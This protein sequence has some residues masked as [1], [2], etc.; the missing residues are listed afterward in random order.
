MERTSSYRE[1]QREKAFKLLETLFRDTGN[2]LFKQTHYPF[3]LQNNL[4]NLWSGIRYDAINYFKENKIPW[5]ENENESPTG[6]L[7]S[8]QLA[9]V[10]HLYYLRQRKELATVILHSVDN[11]I[12]EAVAIDSK[13][14]SGFVDFEVIGKEN[15]LH[16]RSHTRGALSTSIDAVMVGK[17][18]GGKNI[19][20]LIEWKWTE[21]YDNSSHH[22]DAHDTI[23]L[24]LLKETDCPIKTNI[25]KTENF[26]ELYIEPFFQLMRQTLLGWKMSEAK[27]YNCDEYIHL[28]IIPNNNK[29]LRDPEY[30]PGK[31]LLKAWHGLLKE[32][33]RYQIIDPKE[34]M[35]PL[36]NENDALSLLHYLDER[37]W[38]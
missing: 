8:S 31:D 26:L 14:G 27:E 33:K 30:L 29:A 28:H 35:V 15:Y 6:H 19:L 5:W 2:G 10:N 13:C 24:P 20:V 25:L 7:L 16:E 4:L 17:K 37:Y 36:Q 38:K 32:P 11:R 18:F 23:Y 12:Q 34:L 22:K 3:V 21:C 1:E 9:C